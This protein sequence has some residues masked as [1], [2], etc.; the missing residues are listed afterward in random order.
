MADRTV[1]ANSEKTITE[2]VEREVGHEWPAV[3]RAKVNATCIAVAKAVVEECAKIVETHPIPEEFVKKG[4][5]SDEVYQGILAT[6]RDEQRG[7]RIAKEC[8][9][10]EIR[11]LV[12]ESPEPKGERE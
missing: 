7:E 1:Q 10:A 9:A 2:I 3:I 5:R 4:F 11:A 6:I 8:I 12:A